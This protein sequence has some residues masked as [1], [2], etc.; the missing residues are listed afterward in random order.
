MC[1]RKRGG[2]S[3][4]DRLAPLVTR[5]ILGPPRQHCLPLRELTRPRCSICTALLNPGCAG[6]P[7]T[8][9]ETPHRFR[10]ESAQGCSVWLVRIAK[11]PSVKNHGRRRDVPILAVAHHERCHLRRI[12]L[13]HS[14]IDR[15]RQ[16]GQELPGLLA[17]TTHRRRG[18]HR[19]E[20]AGVSEGELP[21]QFSDCRGCIHTVK[22]CLHPATADHVDV[23]DA[24]RTRAHPRHH[25]RQLR[26][27]FADPDLILGAPIWTFHRAV[28]AARSVRPTS[29]PAPAR[30]PICP[31]RLGG[32]I[33]AA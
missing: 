27:R 4:P 12:R 11:P 10:F 22:Q 8:N 29:P 2:R 18:Q 13:P 16:P 5:A 32:F 17:V 33:P 14:R 21:Q 30:A 20:L 19:L 25:R 7:C 1:L 26:R 15:T 9:C 28:A 23:I 24:V 3:I 6:E 31:S